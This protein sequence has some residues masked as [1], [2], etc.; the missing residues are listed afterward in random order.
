M[1]GENGASPAGR[2]SSQGL[3][4][5]YSVEEVATLLRLPRASVVV[6]CRRGSLPA[7]KIARKWLV[8]RGSLAAFLSPPMPAPREPTPAMTPRPATHPFLEGGGRGGR[9]DWG[10][11]LALEPLKVALQRVHDSGH[12]PPVDHR[13]RPGTLPARGE[14]RLTATEV[15]SHLKL[16][17]WKV[18]ELCAGGVLPAV[19]V[20]GTWVVNRV[21]L[22]LLCN[23]PPD[24][25]GALV[26]EAGGRRKEEWRSPRGPVPRHG[27]VT[28]PA[29][30]GAAQGSG[31]RK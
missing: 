6:L 30:H 28:G 7:V 27:E 29:S 19:K 4:P 5:P 9:A 18:P 3:E 23:L 11:P 2:P 15:A 14:D 25:P 26:V 10:T 8:P 16:P 24:A 31:G 22:E 17:P 13:G 1:E 12:K 20:S 21:A